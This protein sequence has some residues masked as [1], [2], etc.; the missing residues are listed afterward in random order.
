MCSEHYEKKCQIT[1]HSASVSEKVRKCY[2]PL[3]KVCSVGENAVESDE[4]CKTYHETSCTSKYVENVGHSSC[5]RI[6]RVLCGTQCRLEESAEECH[7]EDV[8]TI[9][10]TPEESCDLTP[11]KTCHTATKLTPLLT[12]KQ[13]CTVVPQEVCS[14]RL[15]NPTVTDKPLVTKWCKETDEDIFADGTG[16]GEDI[17]AHGT[18]DKDRESKALNVNVTIQPFVKIPPNKTKKTKTKVSNRRKT[19]NPLTDKKI[20]NTKVPGVEN[21]N[22]SLIKQL[23]QLLPPHKGEKLLEL[24]HPLCLN[25][26][27]YLAMLFINGMIISRIILVMKQCLVQKLFNQADNQKRS[28]KH[29]N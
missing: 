16:D 7:E 20:L 5:S 29:L 3:K 8:D 23:S 12:P 10:D 25:L 9:I 27:Q 13:K 14:V 28:I 17:S 2:K 22:E 1:F 19:Q 15:S 24:V 4:I 18:G 21:V 26:C 6:P 11:I